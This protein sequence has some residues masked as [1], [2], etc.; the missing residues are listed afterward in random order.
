M[1][2]RDYKPANVLVNAYGA[3]KLTDFGIAVLAGTDIPTGATAAYAP[4]EQWDAA[5]A[6]PAS[7]VYAATVTFYECLTG[8]RPFSGQSDTTLAEQHRYG[9]VPMAPVPQPLRPLVARGMAKDPQYRPADA[10]AL[11]AELRAI[12]AGAYGEDWESRGRSQLGEAAL[13][14]AALWPTAGVPALQGITIEQARL[15]QGSHSAQGSQSQPTAHA[16]AAQGIP[17]PAGVAGGAAPLAPAGTS[18]TKNTSPTCATSGNTTATA[19]ARRGRRPGSAAPSA[20]LGVLVAVG[21]VAAAVGTVAA[22]PTRIPPTD[23]ARAGHPRRSP[24]RNRSPQFR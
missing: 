9:S 1:V 12:A 7:D 19:P 11:A 4:P 20:R 15:N 21:A 14:L 16:H 5:P 2:H 6:S 3:S 8:Q 23:P 13:L 10:A 22:T 18:A 24:T 17:E